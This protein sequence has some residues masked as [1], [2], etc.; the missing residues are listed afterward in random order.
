M[1]D[2]LPTHEHDARVTDVT[3]M[4]PYLKLI[5]HGIILGNLMPVLAG[6]LLAYGAVGQWQGMRLLYTLIGITGVM[7]SATVWNNIIDR[8]I[9]RHM[10]RTKN[11]PLVN[12][13]ISLEMAVAIAVIASL[14]GFSVL[15]GWVNPLSGHLAMIGFVDY[16]I[17]YS[18]FFKR[19]SRLSIVVGSIS[20][21]V[22]P[23]VGYVALKGQL[24]MTVVCLFI[25]FSTW[26]IAH[27]YAI[28][29]YRKA[30]YLATKIP[31]P[32]LFITFERTQMR[33]LAYV[34]AMILAV[35][36]L[37]AFEVRGFWLPSA[38]VITVAAWWISLQRPIHKSEEAWGKQQFLNSLWVIMVLCLW[39]MLT[40]L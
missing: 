18:L 33:M 10:A 11:R 28:A 29:L 17:L 26:Q 30:D 21:A 40:A 8:D 1:G 32:P 22:P 20:G 6:F 24:D 14:V 16:V 37:A 27:S 25:I 5:K 13:E 19:N 23:L 4:R 9:D 15:Y 35:L 3:R 34:S 38:M 36:Y 12:G 7:I 39:M 31:M 2:V